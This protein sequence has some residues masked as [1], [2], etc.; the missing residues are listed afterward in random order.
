MQTKMQKVK[1]GHN[2]GKVLCLG[3]TVVC[4]NEESAIKFEKEYY[5]SIGESYEGPHWI[6]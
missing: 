3:G 6:K 1:E 2:K 4:D 5:E